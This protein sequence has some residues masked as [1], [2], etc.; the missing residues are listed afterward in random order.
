MNTKQFVFMGL[1]CLAF[2]PQMVAMEETPD[3][4]QLRLQREQLSQLAR[5]RAERANRGTIQNQVALRP[6]THSAAVQQIVRNSNHSE[7]IAPLKQEAMRASEPVHAVTFSPRLLIKLNPEAFFSIQDLISYAPADVV[8]DRNGKSL[9]E[10]INTLD[11]TSDK[12]RIILDTTQDK[13]QGLAESVGYELL[14]LKGHD[15]ESAC[16]AIAMKEETIPTTDESLPC[17][18]AETTGLIYDL[19]MK[20]D[21]ILKKHGLSYWAAYGTLL[22]A[23]RHKGLIP[24]DDDLDICMYED[25]M[26]KFQSLHE[27]LAKEG[28][29]VTVHPRSFLK[30]FPI[31]GEKIKIAEKWKAG[32]G[33]KEHFDW[34][35]P[36]M[37]IFPFGRN[38]NQG[39]IEHAT[40]I[41]RRCY[42]T[43]HFLTQELA[44]PLATFE[45]GPMRLPAPH[46]A[47]QVLNRSYGDDWNE[48]AY[49]QYNHQKE[50]YMRKLKV[51]LVKRAAV[52]YVLPSSNK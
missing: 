30:V 37:D 22:G 25:D 43:D 40:A 27:D 9:E 17:M 16:Y 35:F 5:E 19:M 18:D 15:I 10:Q 2:G 32:F 31:H 23:M 20:V 29:M 33:Y 52:P 44:Q 45:F 3:L 21:R 24:W 34:K 49:C 8:S 26:Q 14:E 11:K 12:H 7:K 1:L 38:A 36:F 41:G 28:L 39:K 48:V 4:K 47:V 6:A 42:P 13:L 51:H 50:D 46:N